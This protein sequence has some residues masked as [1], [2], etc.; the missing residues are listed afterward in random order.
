MRI[1]SKI[2]IVGF[3]L[4]GFSWLFYFIDDLKLAGIILSAICITVFLMNLLIQRIEKQLQ[5]KD[6]VTV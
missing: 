2:V 4:L 1:S 3:I 5:E 6:N